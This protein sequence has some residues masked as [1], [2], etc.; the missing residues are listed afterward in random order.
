MESP[1]HVESSIQSE[2]AVD[3]G[4]FNRGGSADYVENLG[5]QA[6]SNLS[7]REV[8]VDVEFKSPVPKEALQ[9]STGRVSTFEVNERE[10]S[11]AEMGPSNSSNGFFLCLVL[12][13]ISIGAL[14][15]VILVPLSF[16][17]LEYYE[18]RFFID[19]INLKT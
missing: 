17:D 4:D 7:F 10:A 13:I 1:V 18:V 14:L 3:S 15:T 16:S 5:R 6:S 8:G 2:T 11:R 19:F 12:V 9:T